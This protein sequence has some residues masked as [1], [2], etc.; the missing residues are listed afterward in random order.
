MKLILVFLLGL[1]PLLSLAS[2]YQL[3]KPT[4]H[5]VDNANIISASEERSLQSLL[6]PL[7]SENKAEIVVVTV[8]SLNGLPIET[9]SI[10]LAN[11]WELGTEE[12]DNGLIILLAQKEKRVRIEVG[13]GLEGF[14][15]DAFSKQVIDQK[16]LPFFKRGQFGAGLVAGVDTISKKINNEPVNFS[17]KKSKGGFDIV[18]LFM[19]LYF[20]FLFIIVFKAF[21]SK[22]KTGSGLNYRAGHDYDFGHSHGGGS[23]G[24][25][26]GSFGGGGGFSGGGASGGW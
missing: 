6:G 9:A 1:L 19:F 4:S 16:F 25:G 12:D 21:F 14:V 5:V 3:P 22:D 13:Q 15:T 23:F 2:P 17:S 10:E 11:Y 8:T 7:K 24:G 18:S 26:G 20:L